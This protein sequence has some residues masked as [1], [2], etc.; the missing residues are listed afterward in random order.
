[1]LLAVAAGICSTEN[2]NWE[3]KPFANIAH[4]TVHAQALGIP[5]G[6]ACLSLG[7]HHFIFFLL[8]EIR[9]QPDSNSNLLSVS[10]KQRNASK[11]S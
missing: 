9:V 2:V 5:K 4:P 1:M 10:V 11:N 7:R 6:V 3:S 8:S